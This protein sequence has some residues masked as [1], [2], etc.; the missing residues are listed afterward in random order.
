MSLGTGSVAYCL[1]FLERGVWSFYWLAPI[2]RLPMRKWQNLSVLPSYYSRIAWRRGS[3]VYMICFL[4]LG[5]QKVSAVTVLALI[6][7]APVWL[8]PKLQPTS[9]WLSQQRALAPLHNKRMCCLTQGCIVAEL[10][11]AQRPSKFIVWCLWKTRGGPCW[12]PPALVPCGDKPKPV[13]PGRPLVWAMACHVD[14]EHQ[15]WRVYFYMAYCCYCGLMKTGFGGG[16]MLL[17][18]YCMCCGL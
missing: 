10:L 17:G 7:N 8:V 4:S 9:L 11:A 13:L 1:C 16:W 6:S 12:T 14:H 18:M 2:A 5:A 3:V 15:G